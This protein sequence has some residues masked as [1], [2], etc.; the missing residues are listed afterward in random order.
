MAINYFN[1]T[2]SL[3]TF[4]PMDTFS[5]SLKNGRIFEFFSISGCHVFFRYAENFLNSQIS[6]NNQTFD[7]CHALLFIISLRLG[8][9]LTLNLGLFI[10]SFIWEIVFAWNRF[11][12]SNMTL[13]RICMCQIAHDKVCFM[14]KM[15]YNDTELKVEKSPFPFLI[16]IYVLCYYTKS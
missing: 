1:K 5:F 8:N 9:R 13:R 12:D 10:S 2:T 15:L 7:L 14:M 4:L 16:C 3:F 6:T 11:R